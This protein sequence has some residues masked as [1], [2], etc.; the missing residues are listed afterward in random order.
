[1][2]FSGINYLAIFVAAVAA[3][4]LGAIWYTALSRPW[5]AAQGRSPDDFKAQGAALKGTAAFY[6]PFVASF[7][8]EIVMGWVLAGLLGH[9]GPGQVTVSNGVISALFVWLG[10]VAPVVIVNNMYAMRKAALSVIDAGHWLAVLVLIGAIIGW[11][12]N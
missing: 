8:G 3:W 4:V 11:F 12:G 2:T 1:M 9:L 10:F 6:A 5:L 7:I